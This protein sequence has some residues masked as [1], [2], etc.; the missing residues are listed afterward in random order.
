[1]YGRPDRIKITT[2]FF[3]QINGTCEKVLVALK[4]I[5]DVVDNSDPKVLNSPLQNLR[6]RSEVIYFNSVPYSISVLIRIQTP[7]P[8]QDLSLKQG[9]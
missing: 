6:S 5:I 9:Q 8:A 4:E 2:I 1:M 7:D 3:V